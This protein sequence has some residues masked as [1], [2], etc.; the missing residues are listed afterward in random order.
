LPLLSFALSLSLL[1][2]CVFS[3]QIFLSLILF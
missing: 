3:L 1:L 2:S